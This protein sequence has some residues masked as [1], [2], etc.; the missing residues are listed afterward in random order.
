M[1]IKILLLAVVCGVLY[2]FLRPH[3]CGESCQRS[4]REAG[5]S[6][7]CHCACATCPCSPLQAFDIIPKTLEYYYNQGQ[8]HIRELQRQNAAN[9]RRVELSTDESEEIKIND[10]YSSITLTSPLVIEETHR[11]SH[12]NFDPPF[13]RVQQRDSTPELEIA[14]RESTPS[15]SQLKEPPKD[16]RVPAACRKCKS[17]GMTCMGSCP[18]A[19]Q[20][21]NSTN[22][23]K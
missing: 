6:A 22:T 3:G 10:Q 11:A 4:R 8:N 20:V 15:T 16:A 19:K 2:K 23:E 13:R 12:H 7:D 17:L 1:F 9:K 5:T 18:R 14:R 21:N